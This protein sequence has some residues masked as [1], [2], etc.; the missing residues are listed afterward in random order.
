MGI[1]AYTL[2]GDGRNLRGSCLVKEEF[3]NLECSEKLHTEKIID[4]FYRDCKGNSSCFI[5]LK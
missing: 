1:N 5:P 3:G 2:G 4:I